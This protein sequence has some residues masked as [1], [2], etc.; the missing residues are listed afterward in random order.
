M[1]TKQAHAEKR[2]VNSLISASEY[3]NCVGT[4]PVM[5]VLVEMVGHAFMSRCI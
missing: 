4:N 2:P 1:K 5:D 3:Y